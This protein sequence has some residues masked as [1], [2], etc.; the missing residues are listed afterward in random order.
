[1][2]FVRGRNIISIRIS[3][4][5]NV[6]VVEEMGE[7][8]EVGEINDHAEDDVFLRLIAEDAVLHFHVSVY[9]NE[10]PDDHLH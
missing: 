10:A 5:R 9:G 4:F 3:L 1:M 6:S 2:S 8:Y 7:E